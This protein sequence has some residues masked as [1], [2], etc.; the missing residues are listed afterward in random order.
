MGL[1]SDYCWE[2]ILPFSRGGCSL[3]LDL[4]QFQLFS[5]L[6]LLTLSLFPRLTLWAEL[7]LLLW[8]LLEEFGFADS[9][10]PL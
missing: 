3:S 9:A 5:R 1:F 2:E 4:G 7:G 10:N 6:S 8:T